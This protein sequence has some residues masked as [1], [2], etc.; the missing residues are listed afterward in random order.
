MPEPHLSKNPPK[1]NTVKI[2]PNTRS[3]GV[4]QSEINDLPST[5]Y[6]V[7]KP[8]QKPPTAGNLGWIMAMKHPSIIINDRIIKR[9]GYDREKAEVCCL[10]NVGINKSWSINVLSTGE[11]PIEVGVLD[12]STA[13]NMEFSKGSVLGSVLSDLPLLSS[14]GVTN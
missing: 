8:S 5:E 3:C 7:P 6:T 11:S 13:L 4:G 12:E 14:D 1:Q 2:N 9:M 10:A